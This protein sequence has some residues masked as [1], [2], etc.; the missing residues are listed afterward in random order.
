MRHEFDLTGGLQIR[1][2]PSLIKK[3]KKKNN[4][5]S[6]CIIYILHH[7]VP[8]LNLSYMMLKLSKTQDFMLFS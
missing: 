3:T 4:L 6:D 8:E 2:C 5:M 1:Y 7:L